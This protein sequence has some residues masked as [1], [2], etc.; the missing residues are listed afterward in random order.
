MI[1]ADVNSIIDTGMTMYNF[2]LRVIDL[3]KRNS[4]RWFLYSFV[5]KNHLLNF[6]EP[7]AKKYEATS[8]KGVVGRTGRA[9]PIRPKP[10]KKKARAI[11]NILKNDLCM[12]TLLITVSYHCIL[13]PSFI[14]STQNCMP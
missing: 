12:N 1:Q 7:F 3:V 2:F 6:G 11:K 5:D 14:S 13:N 8:K 10:R 9:I 4:A